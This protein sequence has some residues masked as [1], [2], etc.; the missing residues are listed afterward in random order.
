M[1][2]YKL[3]ANPNAV[4]RTVDGTFIPDD[5]R[6]A[7]WRAYQAWLGQGNTPDPADPAP[8]P[9]TP[10]QV[11]TQ[12]INGTDAISVTLRGLIIVLANKF[13][14]TPQAAITAIVNA[15]N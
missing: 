4:Q 8:L 6:N 12:L 9:L 13:S 14:I 15:A 10:Q 7:D 5:P 2:L 11:A 3:L 1:S